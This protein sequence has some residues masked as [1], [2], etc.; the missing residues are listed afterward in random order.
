MQMCDVMH[1]TPGL[2]LLLLFVQQLHCSR[3]W[4]LQQQHGLLFVIAPYHELGFMSTHS[5]LSHWRSY[6]QLLAT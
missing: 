4:A 5:L 6:I 2:L 1:A 3:K